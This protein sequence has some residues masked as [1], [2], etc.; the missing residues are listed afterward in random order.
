M[1]VEDFN[2]HSFNVMQNF[3]HY[4]FIINIGSPDHVPIDDVDLE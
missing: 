4:N 3:Q 1:N 2:K